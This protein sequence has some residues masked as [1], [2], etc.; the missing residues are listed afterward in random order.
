MQSVPI[1]TNVVSTNLAQ[2][3]YTRNNIPVMWKSLSTKWNTIWQRW[4]FGIGNSYRNEVDS[5]WGGVNRRPKQGKLVKPWKISINLFHQLSNTNRHMWASSL[6]IW[7]V[8]IKSDM[9][10]CKIWIWLVYFNISV[11]NISILQFE[12]FCLNI[13]FKKYYRKIKKKILWCFKHLLY[14][15][16]LSNKVTFTQP[17][18]S[19]SA[20]T[21]FIR[22][23][24][25]WN[26]QI[27]NN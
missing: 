12:K 22:Y 3:R 25:Y 27:L 6:K 16:F 21:W 17:V 9:T 13:H 5:P 4:F 14:C 11:I 15:H 26:W 19:V 24:C 8:N 7:T 1:T 23:I 2:V 20:L 18:V 10:W